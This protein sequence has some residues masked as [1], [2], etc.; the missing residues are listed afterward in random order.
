MAIPKIWPEPLNP[1]LRRRTDRADRN[2]DGPRV[3]R[4]DIQPGRTGAGNPA[5]LGGGGDKTS[6]SVST[7][8]G[9]SD[10]PSSYSGQAAKIV[11]VN[12]GETALEF[13]AAGASTSAHYLTSQ[14]ESGLS[15]EVNLGAL[16]TGLLKH[17]VAAGVST[18]A[19]AV[20]GTD[21][22]N[23]GGT[24][25][26]IAD[27]GTGQSTAAAAI[28]ALGA[29]PAPG[30]FPTVLP[31]NGSTNTA[32]ASGTSVCAYLGKAPVTASSWKVAMYQGTAGAAPTSWAEVALCSG[33]APVAASN[34][35]LTTAGYVDISSWIGG[36]GGPQLLTISASFT[37][38]DHMWLVIGEN[39]T[40]RANVRSC[41]ADEMDSGQIGSASARPSTMGAGTA[42][43]KSTTLAGPFA[44]VYPN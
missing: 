38:G 12:A 39:T 35:S 30:I 29:A 22:Y 23:P 19:T 10:V 20:A 7:F 42:F 21:Y 4:D 41:V 6:S 11:A 18:P 34:Q 33:G 3:L 15:A 2:Y 14:A 25:V 13:I 27:G 5:L 43:T 31:K 8:T 32:L 1:E 26:A 17:T 44:Y 37:A 36:A 9:L 16:T 40:T 24:D 28:N